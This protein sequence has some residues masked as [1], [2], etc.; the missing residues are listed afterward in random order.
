MCINHNHSLQGSSVAD[1]KNQTQARKSICIR[2][3]RTNHKF[4]HVEMCLGLYINQTNN[5][6]C[7]TTCTHISLWRFGNQKNIFFLKFTI[8]CLLEHFLSN[9]YYFLLKKKKQQ[10]CLSHIGF[11]YLMSAIYNP[12]LQL[13]RLG[14]FVVIF[15]LYKIL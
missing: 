7:I 10:G 3:A 9:K 6:Y 15:W 11:M 1:D 14:H 13:Q 12:S 2:G 4:V 5:L 8:M